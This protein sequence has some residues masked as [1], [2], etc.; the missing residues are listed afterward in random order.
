MTM[1]AEDPEI[2]D[3]VLVD[4]ASV[5]ET[6]PFEYPITWYGADLPVDGLVQRLNRGDVIIPAFQRGFVWDLSQQ[7]RFVESILLG[8][9]VSG[10]FLSTDADT[11]ELFVIDGHQRL[12]TLRRFYAN[13]L[14]LTS[15]E[16]EFA[17]KTYDTL[18]PQDRRDL[19]NYIL[20]AT[21]VRQ[22]EPSD[23]NSSIYL[24]FE[25]INTGGERLRPQEIRAAIYQGEL[26]ELIG[27]L[28]EN[29]NWRSLFGKVDL[30]MRDQELILRFLA[31]YFN[32]D[33]YKRP[34]TRFLN[35][36]MG[37]NRHLKAQEEAEIREVFKKTM[38]TIHDSLGDRAFKPLNRFVAAQFDAVAVGIANRL[39]Q[40]DIQDR[41]LLKQRYESLIEDD[42][43]HQ[44][45]SVGTDQPNSVERRLSMA[46]EAFSDI[47]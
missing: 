23:D 3:E 21:V 40:G 4:D 14:A 10:I 46:I 30:R 31:L 37:Q 20:H 38:E 12:E 41:A 1:Q 27:E 22:D 26:N 8:L 45:I 35:E 16:S 7:S 5:Y 44:V 34:L 47:P 43:F 32:S 18:N 39:K 24:I 2:T 19:D 6:V 11:K 28:N 17:G 9:P 29:P 33:K 25:R 36:Y 13:E 15:I 42:I